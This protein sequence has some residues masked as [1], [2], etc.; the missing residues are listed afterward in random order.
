MKP[1]RWRR[2]VLL[3]GPF[4]ALYIGVT[5]YLFLPFHDRI[6]AQNAARIEPG[7]TLDEVEQILGSERDESYGEL[8]FF[9]EPSIVNFVITKNG[10]LYK[11]KRWIGQGII[12]T[13]WVNTETA[14]VDSVQTSEGIPVELSTWEKV[15]NRVKA[16]FN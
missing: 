8:T 11:P 2:A 5:C 1:G 15:R 3:A 13:V 6:T 14:R 12:V 9:P 4:A 16:M 7:M 10:P